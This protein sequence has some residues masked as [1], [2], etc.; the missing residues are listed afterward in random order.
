MFC[1]F[2]VLISIFATLF[3]CSNSSINHINKPDWDGLSLPSNVG[4]LD[5]W[6]LI[7]KVS[8]NFNYSG[9]TAEFN[10]KWHDNH[11]RGWKG[12]GAT[13]FSAKHSQLL[14]GNLVL[15]SAVVPEPEQGKIV[16]YGNFKSKKTIYTGF[17]TAKESITYP[18]Y[19]E[20]SMK[21]SSIALASNFWMLSDDDKYEIDVTE[22]YGDTKH[23]VQQMS[24]NYH[25]FKRDPVTN[26]YLEDYGHKAKHYKTSDKALLNQDFHRFGFYWKSP[27]HMEFYLDGKFVR[28]LSS[29]TDLT[30]PD[31]H[32]FDRPMRIIF[33][34]ED[35]VWR[36]RKGI[37]PTVQELNDPT[38]NRMYVD[39]IRAYR[40]AQ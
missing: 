1:R 9:K 17:V 27:T 14:D 20:A 30:D 40:P 28:E 26:E 8:D 11:A 34:M 12:P 29:N 18:I 2:V 5:N 16:D 13:Y 24:T 25:I 36:A 15:S 32:F 38:K 33:D 10:Q 22:T 23:N 21:I 3:S 7:T 31:G 37:T 4:K 6:Q 35:H 19:V 39:W